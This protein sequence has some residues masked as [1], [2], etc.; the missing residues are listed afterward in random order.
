MIEFKAECGHTVRAK[1]EDAGGVVR[2][3]YCGRN[4]AV[5]DNASADLD[6]LFKEVEQPRE[7]EGGGRRRKRRR[8][9]PLFARKKRIRGEFNP[10][11][12]VLRLCY[13]AALFIIVYV[14][15][16]MF[17]MPM[18]DPQKREQ[19]LAGVNPNAPPAKRDDAADKPT[20]QSR[21]VGLIRPRVTG[22]WVAST[23]SGAEVYCVAD[24]KAPAGG[25]IHQVP[26]CVPLRTN[27]EFKNLP[28]GLY[29]VE[30]AFPWN[31]S[32]LKS[33]PKYLEFRKQLKGA[34]PEQ[35]K[36]LAE[37]YFIPDEASNVFVDKTEDQF[38]IVR[39]YR[40]VT[41]RKGQSSSVR[42]LFLPKIPDSDPKTFAIEPLVSLGYIP[43]AKTYEFDHTNVRDELAISGVADADQ[44]FVL[45]ALSRIGLI[46]YMTPE[47]SVLLF[48]IGIQDGVPATR[49][50]PEAPE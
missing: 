6:F 30:V 8:E 35:R 47:R 37:Q 11:A 44:P 21:E 4:A 50:I 16:K 23:P 20:A 18:F 25:R 15:G 14:V 42:A 31:D 29:T 41:V 1:D 19:M 26:G 9:T 34:S 3:S 38:Y 7:P 13:A 10:F 43:N 17:V 48:K 49:D 22:L 39:Q 24:S 2:C 33:Y 32:T 45:E 27:D 12:V 40:G 5:P 28:D 36:R 46:T